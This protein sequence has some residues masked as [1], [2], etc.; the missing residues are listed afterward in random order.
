MK[1]ILTAILSLVLFCT[2]AGCS[3]TNEES[4]NKVDDV[5]KY[6]LKTIN[7]TPTAIPQPE[8]S[9]EVSIFS[10]PIT[11]FM[12]G[13][14]VKINAKL[15]LLL[16]RD[17]PYCYFIVDWGDGTWS[18]NGPYISSVEKRS[19]AELTHIYKKPGTYEVKAAAV[20][21]KTG[22]LYGWSSAVEY[23]IL[24]QATD[25]AII[26]KLVPIASQ[27]SDKELL[28][29]IIDNNQ[30]TS[31]TTL[32]ASDLDDE[33]WI[34]LFFN[35]LYRLDSLEIQFPVATETFPSNIAIEYTTDRGE[36]WQSLPKYYYLYDYSIGRYAPIMRFPNPKGA[37]L[38]LPLDGIVA[39]GIRITAKLFLA[40]PR[41]LSVSEM[42]VYGDRQLLLYTNIGGTFDGDINNMWTIFGTA[43]TEPIVY[44]SING[45]STNQSP[46][47]AGMAMIA[48]TEWLEWN[49]K[50]L[51]WSDHD[52]ARDAF[53]Q[54]L[55]NV[56]YGSDGWSDD[57]GYI[58]ATADSPQHLGEQNHYTY[59]S[60]FII[61][62]RDYLFHGNN[63]KVY[64]N[65]RFVDFLD[66]ENRLGQT[67]RDR[68][69]KAMNYMLKTL[70]GESGILTINDPR[71]D[72]T[73]KGVSS[74]YWDAHRSF[75]Y[76]SAYE[77][78]L[79][80]AS[81][82]AMGDIKNFLHNTE[83][84]E[85]YYNLAAK[86]KEEYNKLFW[87]ETKG[88][89][90]T[91]VNR[92]GE[93]LDFGM[94]FVNI[95]AVAYGV[96]TK[97]RAELIYEWLDGT[98]IIPTDK[99]TG[100]D[101]YGAFVYAPRSN[102]V[103]VS[104]VGP[105]YYWWD[106]GGALPPTEG[107]FGGFDHQMQNGGTIFYISYY[108]MIGRIKTRGSDD[109]FRRFRTI[110]DEFHIDSLRRNSYKPFVQDGYQGIGEYREG[111][112]GEFPESGLVPL[113]FVT[114]FLGI[115]PTGQGLEIAP[116][117]PTELSFAGI[118]EYRFGN[119]L[120]SIQVVRNLDAPE[121][122]YTADK[123][124]LRLPAEKTYIITFDNRLI[125]K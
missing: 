105:P 86:A 64:Q 61:A 125:E 46:F 97:E 65:G 122:R 36:T 49:G 76:K 42:R 114:G 69:E 90:I 59:N 56:R 35:D 31:F 106:H 10:Y 89:Y 52:L 24:G 45:E 88:R 116:N 53:V 62:V 73:P 103:D 115:N 98:R 75:G 101:I 113:T 19:T 11:E 16:A 85:Y 58:Y 74:N 95:Y 40:E 63:L 8:K 109:A 99:S 100:A 102:T 107:A 92:L 84:A 22:K 68:L 94:T 39:D 27:Y 66:A 91:G 33:Q 60:I 47:R 70:E 51:N 111:V 38:V 67:I 119:R 93:R 34:G 41:T 28:N 13:E 57:N 118:R 77:N 9:E 87:D 82:R 5:R 81:L 108:D 2:L 18:Y 37:T 26:N 4:K 32:E 7:Y 29:N 30:E 124:F 48:S 1:K 3:Q 17:N 20:E 21:L 112:I 14:K 104:S 15:N 50:K 96:A 120:Y 123:Y 23:T 12:V 44:G 117:L 55:I 6:D 78:A 25:G 43:K 83:E 80:Y 54:Q 79:F 121:V 72:G 71:N 110:L